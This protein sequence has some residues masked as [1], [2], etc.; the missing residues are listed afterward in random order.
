MKGPSTAALVVGAGLV[1]ASSRTVFA[2]ADP[3]HAVDRFEPSERGSE[4]LANESLD[5]RGRYRPSLGYVVAFSH[6]SLVVPSA[7]G[8]DRAPV[9]EL[10]FLHVGGSMIVLDRVRLALNLPFQLYAGGETAVASGTELPAPPKEGGIGDLRLGAD[11]RVFG[12]YRGP[13]NGAVGFQAWAPTG[14]QSQWASDG[15]F[16]LRPRVMLSGEVGPFV[17]AAQASFFAR[18]RS[19]ITAAGAAGVRLAKAVV[20]G[21]EI[22]ASTVID[23]AFGKSVTPVEAVLGAHWLIDGVGR[24]GG[25]V[26]RGLTEGVGAPAWRAIVGVEWAPD[27]VVVR[28]RRVGSPD[29]GRTAPAEDT[30]RDGI[31]D[32]LD[33]CPRVI[34]IKTNDLKTNG[35]PPDSDEDGIDDLADACP[36]VRGIATSDPET[37]G[38]PERDRDKDG[39]PNDVDACPDDSGPPDIDPRRNGCPKATLH[40]DRIDLFDP[41]EFKPG[42]A[43][44]VASKDTEAVLT[45]VLS[46]MLKLPEGRKLRIEGH[47]DTRGDP[48]MNRQLGAARAAAVAKWLVEHG[49]DRARVSSEGIGGDR[50]IATNETEA[51][52]T[53]NRRLEFHL[54]P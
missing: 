23:D 41:V 46:V 8:S 3:R 13:I 50:P 28:K 45:A 25:G 42:T 17:W 11:V 19:E 12:A 47:T 1:L 21:P 43:E 53:E 33:A 16:R 26:G 9:K 14:Q 22:F 7:D 24:I 40:G 52:R 31:P 49:I 4:W 36:T 20:V 30:D 34:G 2:Q 18:S 15:V 35:C 51:G 27:I 39:V 10:A 29:D 6:R 44:I 38:C 37:N 5:L 54:V 32:A 48:G